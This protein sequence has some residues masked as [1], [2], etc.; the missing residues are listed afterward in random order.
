[1]RG[2]LPELQDPQVVHHFGLEV[3][4][5]NEASFREAAGFENSNDIIE[6]RESGADGKQFISKQPG[7]LK[8]GDITLKRGMTDSM[9]LYEWRKLVVDGK[10]KQA[11]KNGSVIF[12]DAENQEIARF[13]FTRGWPSKWK[14]P[15]V[16]TTNNAVA[17]EEITI[18]HE[19]WERVK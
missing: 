7:N 17:V 2:V 10:H 19:G 13:N 9:A 16:N 8:W 11:R 5:I 6:N 18:A 12:F 1:M 3:E 15:D 14:G 4:G